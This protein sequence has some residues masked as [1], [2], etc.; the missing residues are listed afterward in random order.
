MKRLFFLFA[1]VLSSATLLVAQDDCVGFFPKDEG[2]TLV[3]SNYDANKKLLSTITYVVNKTYQYPDETERQ[4]GFT[5]AD[6]VG[7]VIDEGDMEVRCKDGSFFMKMTNVALTPGILKILMDNT[8]IASEFLDYPDIF[9]TPPSEE[10]FKVDRG[11]FTIRS[12][13]DKKELVNVKVSNRT[14]VKEEK[15]T[16]PAGTFDAYKVTFDV[17]ITEHK[18]V[19]KYKGTEWY[20]DNAGIIK[21]E[22]YDTNNTLVSYSELTTLKF[23]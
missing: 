12:K 20:A 3:K 17:H 1:L 23:K 13:S 6:A 22:V 8:E 21:S 5:I 15:V 18:K 10:L 9:S 11:E 16:T 7:N 14:F 4:I 19:T 2:T